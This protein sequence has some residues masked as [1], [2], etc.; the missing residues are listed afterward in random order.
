MGDCVAAETELSKDA[1]AHTVCGAF[2]EK[3]PAFQ[4]KTIEGRGRLG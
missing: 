3:A 4:C 1:R 2:S